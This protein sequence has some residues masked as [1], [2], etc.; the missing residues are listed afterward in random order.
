MGTEKDVILNL[1]IP[2]GKDGTSIGI[3]EPEISVDTGTGEP[4][5][6]VTVSAPAGRGF[7]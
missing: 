2:K 5:A 4:Y 6:E 7:S 1:T 3:G